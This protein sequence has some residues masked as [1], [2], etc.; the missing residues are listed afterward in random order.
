MPRQ[1]HL[2]ADSFLKTTTCV[3]SFFGAILSQVILNPIIR[4]SRQGDTSGSKEILLLLAK[5]DAII[6]RLFDY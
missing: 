6:D 4:S 1:R 5:Q 2:L 3:F